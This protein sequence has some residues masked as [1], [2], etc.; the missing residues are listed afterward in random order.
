MFRVKHALGLA[1]LMCPLHDAIAQ[2]EE[3]LVPREPNGECAAPR[4]AGQQNTYE[5]FSGRI[6]A[7]ELV[8]PLGSDVF[9]DSTSVYN[10][11]TEFSVIDIDLPGNSGLPVQARRRLKID[12]KKTGAPFG[13]FGAWDVDVPHL[14]GMF[15]GNAANR[16]NKDEFN[17]TLLGIRC[18]NAFQPVVGGN[19]EL[20]EVWNGFHMHIPGKGSQEVLRLSAGT[21]PSPS[22][23]TYLWSTRDETRFRCISAPETLPHGYPGEGFI[24]VDTNGTEYRFDTAIERS[25]GIIRRK[26]PGFGQAS[27]NRM[28]IYLM[29]SQVKDRHGNTVNYVYSADGRLTQIYAGEGEDNANDRRRI[30]F[31]YNGAGSTATIWRARTDAGVNSREWLYHYHGGTLGNITAGAPLWRV[32]R[33]DQSEWTYTYSGL[34]LPGYF[35]DD[36]HFGNFCPMPQPLPSQFTLTATHPAGAVGEFVFNY[37]QHYRSGI[38]KS[39]CVPLDVA[40]GISR[41]DRADFFDNY[42]LSIKRVAHFSAGAN[43]VALPLQQWTYTY[44]TLSP[45]PGYTRPDSVPIPCLDDVL[46]PPSK[47]VTVTQPDGSMV[48][49]E[50]GVR[51]SENEGRLLSTAVR[52]TGRG[53]LRLETSTY[54]T[55]AEAASMPFRDSYGLFT[56][57]DDLRTARIRP[58]K[59][60]AIVQQGVT[61]SA[62]TTQFDSLA[63]PTQ[64]LRSSTLGFTRTDNARYFDHLASWTMGQ[65]SG[66]WD[67]FSCPA[68]CPASPTGTQLVSESTYDP[69]TA[70]P[71]RR[72]AHGK[73]TERRTYHTAVGQAGLPW[74]IFDGGDIK[75]TTL[76]SYR[77]GL[78]RSVVYHDGSSESAQVGYHG[79]IDSVTNAVFATTNYGYDDMGRLDS[80]THPPGPNPEDS[81]VPT[82]MLFE[83]VAANEYGI[84][85]GHWR[86]TV[87]TGN[88]RTV[89]YFDGLWRPVLTRIF[90]AASE[91]TTRRMIARRFDHRNQETFASF[92][93]RSIS[94]VNAVPSATL[95]PG[96]V[97]T[98]DALGRPLTTGSHSEL[99]AGL[100]STSFTY[101]TGFQTRITDPRLFSTTYSYQAFDQPS[102]DRPVLV[103]QPLDTNTALVRDAWGKP[104]SIQ[105]YGTYSNQSQSLTR[106]YVY[107]S[108]Q[109]LCKV[110]DPEAGWT[111]TDY[112]SSNNVA[113]TALGQALPSLTDCQRGNVSGLFKSV[114]QYDGRNRMISIDHPIGTSDVGYSYHPDGALAGTTTSTSSWTYGYNQ[115]RLLRTEALAA[116]SQTLTLTHHY[117]ENGHRNA[118]TYPDALYVAFAPNALGEPTQA[119]SFAHSASYHPNGALAGF[120]YGNSYVHTTTLTTRQQPQDLSDV[121]FGVNLVN[122]GHVYD[123]AGNLTGRLDSSTGPDESRS[124]MYD[125]LNRL[126]ETLATGLLGKA[127]YSWDVLDNLRYVDYDD[128]LRVPQLDT[129]SYDSNNRL[130]QIFKQTTSASVALPYGHDARGNA[131]TRT[132]NQGTTPV[133][134]SQTFDYANRMTS[135]QVDNQ[136]EYYWYDGHGRRTLIERSTNITMQL[137][138]QEG[139]FLYER[140]PAG[141]AIKHVHLGKRLVASITGT[142]PLYTH[143]DALGSVV[144]RS[145]GAGNEV[146]RS[147]VEPFGSL[148]AGSW[149]Q[150]PGFTGH[151]ADLASGLTY[152]QQRYQDPGAMRFLSVDPLHVDATT[153]GNFN[154]YWYANNNPYRFTDPDGQ[155]PILVPVLAGISWLVVSEPANAPSLNDVPEPPMGLVEAGLTLA[156]GLSIA[157]SAASTLKDAVAHVRQHVTSR[158]AQREAQRQARIPTSRSSTSQTGPDGQRQHVVEGADGTPNVVTQHPP[159]SQHPNPHWHAAE[160]KT[161]PVSGEL[162]TNRYGQIKYK[163]NGPAV[164]YEGR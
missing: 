48:D 81:W 64:V 49:H 104:T 11:A 160:A 38:D 111:V 130:N 143:T 29:A 151:V 135:S 51:F 7:S 164:E 157:K 62:A 94:D 36:A 41:L 43:S 40:T 87:N 106:R 20:K 122:Y 137:Y 2:D 23:G 88:A 119:G 21:T 98:Y 114:R 89:T 14:M 116:N 138:D 149:I 156:D 83:P 140:R 68:P 92:P 58:V 129:Y 10:G 9:G 91:S 39:S 74:Q 73:Q 127:E 26:L 113:W 13:G 1:L 52:T 93:S 105:R 155:L 159:D 125:G 139:T 47:V 90:D 44:P 75:K 34:L 25:Q 18:S 24:A 131:T 158:A 30:F 108:N 15:D 8:T 112:D 4:N 152:M 148:S 32:V 128:Y 6:R 71:V 118:L 5:A 56:G 69:S 37:R 59:L 76:S 28:A 124:M 12:S 162:R 46:C 100:V 144:R 65:V 123:P 134:R 161:D 141:L 101:L 109:R 120:T 53:V 17:P 163:P 78:P 22:S 117:N 132:T 103:Q 57:S 79:D 146:G 82:T 85:A 95:M 150:G 107:D 67:Q 110:F 84:P 102:T 136:Y 54:V 35:D 3:C 33:P 16:W 96:K 126:Q 61:F 63:R 133:P 115:R 50:F 66:T 77:R 55:D 72:Y 142:T 147:V 97:S 45:G 19:L 42:S 153:G 121:R 70:L 99:G 60:T 80:I 145:D 31:D 27:V 154:R 86:H